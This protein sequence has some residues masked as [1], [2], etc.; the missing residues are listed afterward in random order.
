MSLLIKGVANFIGLTDTPATYTGKPLKVARVKQTADGLEFADQITQ[1]EI[2]TNIIPDQITQEFQTVS[3]GKFTRRCRVTGHY[4]FV[5]QQD[6][7]LGRVHILDVSDVEAPDVLASFDPGDNIQDVWPTAKYFYCLSQTPDALVVCDWSNPRSPSIVTQF[8]HAEIDEPTGLYIRGRYA[9][10][11]SRAKKALVIVDISAPSAP[12]YVGHYANATY[13]THPT[14][15]VVSG[16]YAFVLSHPYL[17]CVNIADPTNPTSVSYL[18]VKLNYSN[19]RDRLCKV[20]KYIYLTDAGA[21][22]HE[23]ASNRIRI[24][25]VSN[26]ASMSIVGTIKDDT[27]LS[28]VNGG[29]TTLAVAGDWIFTVSGGTGAEGYFVIIDARDKANPS[30][31][32]TTYL[33][34]GSGDIALAGKYAFIG[35]GNM[36]AANFH[37]YSVWSI[38]I[39]AFI[40]NSIFADYIFCER[41]D[42]AEQISG[43][44]AILDGISIPDALPKVMLI[45]LLLAQV[46]ATDPGTAYVELSALYRTNVDFSKLAVKQARVIISGIGNEATAGKGIE[47]YNSTDGAAI[48]EVTWDGDAQQNGLV[49]TWTDCNLRAAKDIQVRVKASSV[50]EDITVDKVEL[51]VLFD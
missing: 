1:Y 14:D 3:Y 36:A 30:I 4:C 9:Y 32:E 21:G 50:T 7:I 35:G 46:I 19:Y 17:H 31:H 48:C 16:N 25:D 26:P 41:L 28:G 37:I 20:G 49:G 33:G 8:T 27:Y 13:L 18:S 43:G 47:I 44:P 22:T 15:V 2:P 42:V 38:D 12:R 24:V 11:A 10:I 40:G 6:G 39:P 45:P 29:V 23:E 5:A 51:Q 34:I